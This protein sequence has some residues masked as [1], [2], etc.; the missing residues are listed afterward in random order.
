MSPN[1]LQA[2]LSGDLNTA[3]LYA[4]KYVGLLGA[5]IGYERDEKI[6][7]NNHINFWILYH[8]M[9][10]DEDGE[11]EG[12]KYGRVIAI[13]VATRSSKNACADPGDAQEQEAKGDVKFTYSVRWVPTETKWA[14]RWDPLI[15]MS[16]QASYEMQRF[17]RLT[18]EKCTA[19]AS[20]LSQLSSPPLSLFS[21]WN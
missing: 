2:S 6:Y 11:E 10:P 20:A 3:D 17:I 14:S 16:Q 18:L 7:I 21:F 8:P 5:L 19:N 1:D 15:Q 12:I 13:Y 4:K 9:P